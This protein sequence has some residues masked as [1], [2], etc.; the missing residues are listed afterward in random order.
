MTATKKAALADGFRESQIP[1]AAGG[2]AG[3][4]LRLAL[5]ATFFRL[6]YAKRRLCLM[7]LLYCLPIRVFTSLRCFDSVCVT[8]VI[9]S[10]RFNIYLL[11]LV[12]LA[13]FVGCRSPESRRA[14]QLATF[15]IHLEVNPDGTDRNQPVPIYRAHPTQVNVDKGPFLTEG[16]IAEAMVIVDT[17]NAFSLQI[18]FDPR[19][20]LILEQYTA[21]NSGKRFAIF[22]EFGER[23]EQYRWLGAPI[24]PRRISNGILAFTPD[25]TRDET[26]QIAIG[27]NNV[28]IKNGN[29]AKQ[30][31]SKPEAK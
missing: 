30:K 25:A 14:K 11:C 12:L 3:A 6:R 21:M 28:A 29:Q 8:M 22:S 5:A 1:Q 26:E 4:T 15:R 24:I 23:M 27:L 20:T 18:Q 19:A 2:A 17:V 7:P 13:P 16:D 31:T 9:R 10:T